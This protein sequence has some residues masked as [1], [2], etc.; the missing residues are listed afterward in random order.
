MATKTGPT[1][2][3]TAFANLRK[4]S[5][6]AIWIETHEPNRLM[7]TVKPLT[8]KG[9]AFGWDC[10]TGMR[11]LDSGAVVGDA[12]DPVAVVKKMGS[13][14]VPD[15][16]VVY[17]HNFHR[18]IDGAESV[19]TVQNVLEALKSTNKALVVVAPVLQLPVELSRVFT[20][21]PFALPTQD[22]VK[23][24][25]TYVSDSAEV[26][27]SD[28]DSVSEAA[29]GLTANEAENAFALSLVEKKKF[30]TRTIWSKKADMIQK[31]GAL[32]IHHGNESF[33]NLGGLDGAKQFVLGALRS[34]SDVQPKGILLLGVPGAGKSEFCK[35]LGNETGLDV[36]R[37]DVGALYG[38][39]VGDSEKN[40]RQTLDTI[41]A[42]GRCIVM[43]DE[44]EKAMSG[45]ASSGQTDG[46][47]SARVFGS[48][49][50][51]AQDHKSKA[52]LVATCNK[53]QQLPPEFSR[54]GRWDGLFF[55]DL[56]NDEQRKTIWSIH[57]KKY[58][59]MAKDVPESR[60]WTG[61]EIESCCRLAA[62]H[63]TD[64]ISASRYVV[65]IAV[66]YREDIETLREW[67]KVRAIDANTGFRYGLETPDAPEAPKKGRKFGSM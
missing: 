47:T 66:S 48:I 37:F 8:P 34:K 50:S 43:L 7:T 14:S 67:A 57:M 20:V 32:K 31:N 62:L 18:F 23:E 35:A 52:Y 61:A 41:D 42:F 39:L 1:A 58:N 9:L 59:V 27:V 45:V 38:S 5:Y 40:T 33:A 28:P 25:L 12:A 4:A 22:E 60:D 54:A 17:L 15:G 55:V 6:P 46:G 24:V 19:Q 21:L 63:G 2:F 56:P 10:V 53:I 44:V 36:I 13:P 3:Q 65:P 11:N 64:L 49:L 51:W 26:P 29:L 16:A 30:D